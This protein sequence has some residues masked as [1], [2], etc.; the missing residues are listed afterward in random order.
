[1]N[2]FIR[3]FKWIPVLGVFLVTWYGLHGATDE[4]FGFEVKENYWGAIITQCV[5]FVLLI[6][7]I[8]T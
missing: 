6:F 4:Q 2:S 3:Y 5:S 7:F 1:M 8:I